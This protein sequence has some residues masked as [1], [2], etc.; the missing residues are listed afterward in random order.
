LPLVPRRARRLTHIGRRAALLK[1]EVNLGE[2]LGIDLK[3]EEP[4][5]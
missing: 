3:L 2:G 4:G 5:M 1:A